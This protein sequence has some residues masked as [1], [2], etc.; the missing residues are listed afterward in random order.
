[1]DAGVAQ[2]QSGTEPPVVGK[3]VVPGL[4]I[5]NVQVQGLDDQMHMLGVEHEIV[6]V[7]QNPFA[8]FSEGADQMIDAMVIAC[9]ADDQQVGQIGDLVKPFEIGQEKI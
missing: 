7:E 6:D 1:R 9:A 2:F 4:L 8:P 5:A 3:P